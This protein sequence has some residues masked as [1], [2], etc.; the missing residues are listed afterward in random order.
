MI[1]SVAILL[2]GVAWSQVLLSADPPAPSAKEP[3]DPEHAA[4]MARGLDL[5]KKHVRP[6]LVQRCLRCHG[7]EVT[8][9]EFDIT[10]RP[11]LLK[12]GL[13]GPAIV[14]GN[15][16]ASLLFHVVNHSKKPRMPHKEDK[17]PQEAIQHIA[18]WIDLGAPFDKPLVEREEAV[19]W[20][21]RVVP[22]EARHHW[23][24]Q[25]LQNV[26]PPPGVAGHPW[27][28]N[29]IDQ[30]ILDRLQQAGLEP[31]PVA[32]RRRLIRRAYFGLLGLPPRP[33]EVEAF[34]ADPAPDAYEKLL[35]RLLASQHYGERWAR[36]WL[37]VARFAES[38]GFEHDYDRPTA[39]HYRDFVIQALN[40]DLPYDVFVRWQI[41]GDELA[42]DNNLALMAT[43][44]L[45]AGVHSTQITKNE[46]E[47]HRYDELDD[48]LATTGSAM[49]GL[50]LGCAR[51]HDHKYDPIPQRDYYQMLSAFTTTVR[52]EVDLDLDPEG[53]RQAKAAFDAEHAPYQ[54]AVDAFIRDQLPKRLAA[55][56][57]SSASTAYREGRVWVVIE[58]TDLKSQGGAKLT[59][60]PDGSIVAEGNNPSFDIYTVTAKS[61]LPSIR[62]IRLEALA[63]GKLPKGGP[64][65]AGNGNFALSD[66]RLQVLGATGENATGQ[67]SEGRSVPL[68]R[69]RA[70]FEQKGL[71]VAQIVDNDARSAWA[72]DPQFGKNHQAAVECAEPLTDAIGKTLRFALHFNNNAGHNLGRFRLAVTAAE[73]LDLKADN[74][75]ADVRRI[76][77]TAADQRS[78][79]DRQKL[80][81][82]YAERDPELQRL[83]QTAAEHLKKAPKPKIVKAM[84]STEGLPAVRLH[85]QGEDF[86]P[87]TY[88]LR[89]GD[90]AQKEGVAPL[91][92]LQVLTRTDKPE[93]R[94]P[95]KP[96]PGSRTSFR[97]KALADWLTDV[98]CGAGH[99][100]ARVIVNR[101]WQ[102]HL[103]RGIVAT[104]ND[105]GTRGEPPTHPELLDW[106]A[107][108]LIRHGWKLKPMHKLIM[109]S[110][111]YMQ[112]TA[113]DPAKA[114]KDPDNRLLW[115]RP[116]RR[117]EGEII[118]DA[119][120]ALSGE[121]DTR[122]FG[123]GTLDPSS[124]RRSIYFTVKRSQLMPMMV[125]FDAPEALVSIGERP[126]TTIAPQAL[127]MMNN[128]QVRT[129]ARG[130]AR[131]LLG[132]ENEPWSEIVRRGYRYALGRVPEAEEQAASIAFVQRQLESYLAEGK[133]DARQLAVADFCQVLFCMNEF[134]YVD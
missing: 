46:V 34:V 72:V 75:P 130:F 103:G 91:G 29:P 38:H 52:S 95:V 2:I 18:Q 113:F 14:P 31:N 1:R 40:D 87:E 86:F 39:Y 45:A 88:F 81:A 50:T 77:L 111:T 93:E 102:H 47:K 125:V 121:M 24:L 131:R 57:A 92:F 62:G 58:P 98:E 55:W 65:R 109:S 15:S 118:R 85:T 69:P 5:F 54:A 49:L 12:G 107:A 13:A 82:W 56:E 16:Q 17:L 122:M 21:K 51:C 37:D 127:L 100:L 129:Y 22:P 36:H 79:T 134:V 64:G 60:Q 43:G 73:N 20:T 132:D 41:A 9:S 42:P 71:P 112:S 27:V 116:M 97:R 35:D 19:A 53:Y 26:Q 101:L 67:E 126:T 120:L 76:L 61:E 59:F 11:H 70:S 74:I 44:F 106:L 30:F 66:F 128:P 108:E 83:R 28:R 124:K 63:D 117:L 48:M 33:E 7:G 10:D 90:P 105:F 110:A 32:D 133:A 94:W 4:K 8:E 89:R 3:L 115:R 123:P 25:P 114:A 99:L 80:L 84:I 23:S 68:I 78:D 119:M 96:P 104:A 6:V